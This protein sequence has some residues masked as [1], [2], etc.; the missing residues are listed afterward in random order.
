L[1]V[2]WGEAEQRALHGHALAAGLFQPRQV[3]RLPEPCEVVKDMQAHDGSYTVCSG[4]RVG[5][6]FLVNNRDRLAPLFIHFHGAGETAADYREPDLAARYRDLPAH[7][8]V[9]DFRGYGWS[10]GQSSLATLFRDAEPLAEKLPE[11]LVQHGLAWPYP[12]GLILSGH[13]L[14]AQV[15]VHLAAMFPGLFR[16]LVLDSAAGTSAT[17]DRLGHAAERSAALQRWRTE[18]EKA[19]LEVLQPLD[20]ELRSLGAL[21]KVRGYE[22]QLLVMHSLPD[23]DAPFESSE[24]L[25]A[26]ARM[27]RKELLLLKNKGRSEEYWAAMRCFAAKIQLDDTLPKVGAVVEH[28]CAICAEKATSKCGRCQRVWYCGRKHQAEH[29]KVHKVTCAGGPPESTEKVQPE[30]EACVEAVL[31]ADVFTD[32]DI[33]AL[34]LC[35]KAVAEQTEHMRMLH[36]SWRAVSSALAERVRELVG[37][38][39][40]I[41]AMRQPPLMLAVVEVILQTS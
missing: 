20:A 18:L 14:G 7:L 40:A 11:I 16:G 15:A 19:N 41:A 30:A 22:G 17:G 5:Y 24:S 28:L 2:A 25:H 36:V 13:E 27:Q 6:V 8:M 34:N 4:V 29:W 1:I 39:G 32:D 35:F 33:V 12:S 10:A 31:I 37:D 38:L 9:I 23:D 26:A 3:A 21:E